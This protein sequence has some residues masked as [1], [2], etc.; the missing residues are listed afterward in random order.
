MKQIVLLLCLCIAGIAN[1]GNKSSKTGIETITFYGVDFSL[2]KVYAADESPEKFITAFQGI[3]E[4]FKKEPKKYDVTKAFKVRTATTSLAE[5]QAQNAKIDCSKLFVQ[6][7]NYSLTR[8]D[9][10]AQIRKFNTGTD[11]GYGAII[12]AGLLNK[13]KGNATYTVVIFNIE[14]KE[15]VS[16]QQVTAKA[17]GFGLRNYW[18]GSVYAT[19]KQIRKL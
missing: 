4:L 8:E 1:A 12:F 3:N 16:Q 19:L 7:N 9:I 15:I 2:T 6:S 17:K 10:D 5:V 11:K 14:T 13:G 18:A